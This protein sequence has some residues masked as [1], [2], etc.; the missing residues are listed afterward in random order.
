[1][2]YQDAAKIVAEQMGIPPKDAIDI[3]KSYWFFI[4]ENIKKLPLKQD[5]TKEEFDKL[6][7]SFNIPSLGKFACT[8]DQYTVIKRNYKKIHNHLID[9]EKAKEN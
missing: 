8:Y 6:K 2:R 9:N 3:Y 4:K 5:L 7:T 1:M